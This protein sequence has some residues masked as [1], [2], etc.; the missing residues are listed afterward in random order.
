M[1]TSMIFRFWHNI[2]LL[3]LVMNHVVSVS[4]FYAQKVHV[5]P[6]LNTPLQAKYFEL[7]G[8]LRRFS[9]SSAFNRSTGMFDKT[10]RSTHV[11]AKHS[12]SDFWG[13]TRT[14]ERT[15]AQSSRPG[16][17]FFGLCRPAFP[18]SKTSCETDSATEGRFDLGQRRSV[19]W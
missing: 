14:A 7:A 6:P 12:A 8:L 11:S 9:R 18:P 17:G 2:G 15:V 13:K 19:V 5:P 4:H 3:L 1:Q 10:A 16:G